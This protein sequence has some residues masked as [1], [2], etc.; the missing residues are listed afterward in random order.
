MAVSDGGSVPS[1]SS[2]RR[3]NKKRN[4]DMAR[5]LYAMISSEV[6][7]KMQR[8]SGVL[9]DAFSAPAMAMQSTD[10]ANQLRDS[11]GPG[12][13]GA[14]GVPGSTAAGNYGPATKALLDTIAV[15][16][17]TAS[18]PNSGY[19]THFGFD[20]YSGQGYPSAHPNI[21]K[22]TS[23]YSSAAFGPTTL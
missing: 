5:S 13:P 17:G 20:Q 14:G 19:L 15:A 10:P 2:I 23:R 16:E 21:V 8:I 1:L 6:N 4:T 7:S 9:M 3:A 18:Q 22:R 12:G 11:A